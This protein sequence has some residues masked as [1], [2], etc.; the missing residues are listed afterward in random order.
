MAPAI[1]TRLEEAQAPVKFFVSSSRAS[2]DGNGSG[3]IAII[4][5]EGGRLIGGASGPPTVSRRRA[6]TASLLLSVDIDV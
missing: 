2:E 3:V 4:G 5:L 6:F 1:L